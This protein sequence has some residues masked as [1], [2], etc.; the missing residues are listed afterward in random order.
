MGGE[1]VLKDQIIQLANAID[2]NEG[3]KWDGSLGLGIPESNTI[4]PEIDA[5]DG[6][7]FSDN[8]K[9]SLNI[10]Q[11]AAY[12]PSNATGAYDF[13]ALQSGRYDGD[14]SWAGVMPLGGFWIVFLTQYGTGSKIQH[15][16]T[17]AVI[18]TTFPLLVM[19]DDLV[20]KHYASVTGAFLSDG[21]YV[22]PCDSTI[23]KLSFML[24]KAWVD[25]P[26]ELLVGPKTEEGENQCVGLLQS[27]DDAE[28]NLLGLPFFNAYYGIFN[29]KGPR[30]G[31]AQL[32]HETEA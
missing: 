9:V 1:L 4:K 7:L 8:L 25:I 24:G 23:P 32:K 19:V 18:D 5:G 26:G 2:D 22:F 31:W 6:K 30:F 16:S 13:G 27:S 11:F 14:I 17:L 15:S 12:L 28:R 20:K 21:N 3:D 29:M 10:T